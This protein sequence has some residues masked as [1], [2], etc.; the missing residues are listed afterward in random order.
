MQVMINK[1]T[2]DTRYKILILLFSLCVGIVPAAAADELVCPAVY[3]CDGHGN[4]IAEFSVGECGIR[5]AKQCASELTNVIAAD[6]IACD[7]ERTRLVEENK[8]LEKQVKKLKRQN[9][10]FKRKFRR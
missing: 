9:K 10:R 8:Q 6:L 3:P 1:R 2:M 7:S 4:V 5:F